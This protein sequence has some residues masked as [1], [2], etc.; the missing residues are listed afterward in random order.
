MI[1]GRRRRHRWTRNETSRCSRAARASGPS[2]FF[3]DV[4]SCR[5]NGGS[6]CPR[7][8]SSAGPA[9]KSY[10]TNC[11]LLPKKW[12]MT[13]PAR[14]VA[15]RE[16]MAIKPFPATDAAY[17]AGFFDGE[18]SLT[19]RHAN[20]GMRRSGHYGLIVHFTNKNLAL[21]S[22]I[23]SVAGGTINPKARRSEKHAIAYELTLC[24]PS[25]IRALLDVI[26]PYVRIKRAQLELGQAFLRL[27]RVKK[28]MIARQ[29]KSWPIFR[30]LQS[31]INIRDQFKRKL[32][33]LNQ[34]GPVCPQ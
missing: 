33:M 1:C 13:M 16:A 15:Q 29:G 9:S 12:R 27:G 3:A 6:K 8:N 18:G 10:A 19:I 2:A 24:R 4:R 25:E 34:R 22:W 14:S 23:K 28:G 5:H 30:A 32:G 21:L 17:I 11:S 31:E 26:S 20:K 7:R